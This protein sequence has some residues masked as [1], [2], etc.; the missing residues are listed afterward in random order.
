M[1]MKKILLF[2]LAAAVALSS[3]S[4]SLK[5]NVYTQTDETF[6]KD[7]SMAETVLY[8]LY[9][10]LGVDGIYGLNLS[11]IFNF[12]TDE[13]KPEGSTLVGM[14]IEGFN[15]FNSAST[16]VQQSWQALYSAVYD[17]NYYIEMINRKMS[18]FNENDQKKAQIYL[19]EAHAIRGLLYFELVRWF[20][21]VPLVTSTSESSKK[22]EEFKQAD[23]VKV[24]EQIETDL[25]YAVEVLPYTTEDNIR[26][27]N[28]F[29]MSKGAALGI[30]AK[31][32]ATWAG[33]PLMDE[34]KWALAAE[35]AGTL[36]NS[37]KHALL[38]DFD[39]LWKN[40]G[41]NVWDPTES[42]LELSYWSPLTTV[43]SSGRIGNF[44]GVR[45]VAGGL[46]NGNHGHNVF[47]YFNPTFL[48]GWK[49]YKLDKRFAITYA[50]YQYTKDAGRQ[51][52]CLKTVDGVKNSEVSFL[53]AWEGTHKDYNDSWRTI[54][55][56]RLT[57]RKW[58]TEI[59]VP[60]ENYQVDNNYTNINWYVLRYSDV[61][62][63]YAEALNEVNDG[64]TAEAYEAVNM[65][66][67]RG[68]GQDIT[69]ASEDADLDAGL[70]Y[71][72]FQKAI[73]DERA[74]ELAG[75]GHRRQDLIR[76]GIYYDTVMETY[77]NLGS[78]YPTAS[79][80]FL[81]G[82]YTIKGKHELLP[83]PQREVDLCG[84]KQNPNW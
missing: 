47:W 58:D 67:R 65:V 50:D 20:G 37:N 32:Y 13:S 52:Y 11:M 48:T 61:L 16:Y 28:S 34:S 60:D 7:A 71:E 68:F 12:S 44:N 27:N 36:V 25:K 69:T 19:A 81:G 18:E 46:R 35:T 2:F 83:I 51:C 42:L 84:Y 57:N 43:E 21:N 55:S 5:E 38:S 59:Y 56:Y 78:W 40:S 41:A 14:R 17:T 23:P 72:E 1:N 66:R 80:Y 9:R 29:R 31:V 77:Q 26:G 74:W 24:Y 30:L 6:V 49:D 76:W 64:P 62:L 82:E 4:C 22:A 53:M 45:A 39:Q 63:L 10:K 75:E 3:I 73:R 8:G 15:A 79:N 70:S 54:Y 33:Y